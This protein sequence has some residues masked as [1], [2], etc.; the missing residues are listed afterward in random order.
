MGYW[1]RRLS[2]HFRFCFRFRFL[3]RTQSNFIWLCLTEWWH[4]TGY[5]AISKSAQSRF[6]SAIC[7]DKRWLFW[8]DVFVSDASLSVATQHQQQEHS[9]R[10]QAWWIWRRMIYTS[11]L[12][13]C[14]AAFLKQCERAGKLTTACWI[15]SGRQQYTAHTQY[16]FTNH[17]LLKACSTGVWVLEH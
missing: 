9:T 11:R 1:Y 14:R 7:S 6:K 2:Y 16:L 4:I 5:L 17:F 8:D 12:R 3:F 10:G 13:W 15:L